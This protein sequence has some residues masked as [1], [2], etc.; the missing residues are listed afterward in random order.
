MS[1]CHYC[2]AEAGKSSQKAYLKKYCSR[3]CYRKGKSGTSAW[4]NIKKRKRLLER[5]RQGCE[6]AILELRLRY[7]LRIIPLPLAD[8]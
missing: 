6:T 1:E 4:P 5:A 8:R 3:E 2:G 7:G